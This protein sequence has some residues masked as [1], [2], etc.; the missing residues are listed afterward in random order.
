MGFLFKEWAQA[1]PDAALS[2]AKELDDD[3][4]RLSALAG[5]LP[6]WQL[7]HPDQ[8]LDDAV[9]L[10]SIPDADY[11]NIVS[12]IVSRW[13][14]ADPAA[15]MVYAKSIEDP[16]QKQRLAVNVVSSW[17]V[18][19][20]EAARQWV[21]DQP[22][23]PTRDHS[24]GTLSEWTGKT[25]LAAA[26]RLVSEISD[27]TLRGN[28]AKGILSGSDAVAGNL[29][30]AL[31]LAESVPNFNGSELLRITGNVSPKDLPRFREWVEAAAANRFTGSFGFADG[32][33]V[34]RATL[35]YIEERQKNDR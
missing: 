1:D 31:A 30:D 19:D 5:V 17:M 20:P 25:D 18:K 10:A 29:T 22:V 32:D 7:K 6:S 2:R 28:T 16:A 9:D 33:E 11:A 15:A 12:T 13:A 27:A 3:T 23:G 34:K 4:E 8:T 14:M 21:I 24:L 35:R 26:N